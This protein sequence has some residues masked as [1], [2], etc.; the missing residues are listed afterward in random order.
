MKPFTK[1]NPSSSVQHKL[2][3]FAF[4]ALSFAFMGIVYSLKFFSVKSSGIALTPTDD[5]PLQE[6][7]TLFQQNDP[8]WRSQTLGDSGKTME[9]AG[10][11]VTSVANSIEALGYTQTP[12]ELCAKLSAVNGFDG[13]ELIWKKIHDAF[14]AVESSSSTIFSW[15]DIQ[16]DLKKGYSPIVHVKYGPNNTEHWVAVIGAKE[17]QF[18][19]ADPLIPENPVPLSVY[20][21]V[22]AYFVI[23]PSD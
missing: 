2:R 23:V 20:G 21:K 5:I 14:P 3:L 11:L 13:S 15:R 19:V 22:Y 12:G 17:G 10:C 8:R 1:Q 6:N 16:R 4:V 7:V 18:W 9:S